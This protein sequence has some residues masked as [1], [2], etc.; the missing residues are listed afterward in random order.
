MKIYLRN[1]IVRTKKSIEQIDFSELVTFINGPVG[2]GKSTVARLIDYCFG[3]DLERTPA[4]QS[5]F[6]SAELNVTL[7]VYD[8]VIERAAEDTSI[9]RV[10]WSGPDNDIGSVNAPLSPQDTSLLDAEVYNFSD[11]IFHLCGVTP[12]MVK[13]RRRDPDSEMIRL[14]IRDILRYCYLEQDHL[15][16]SFFSIDDPFRGRKSQDAMRFFTGLHSERLSQIESQL[17]SAIDEQRGKREAVKQIREFMDMFDLGSKFNIIDYIDEIS[18]ELNEAKTKRQQLKEAR[19]VQIH[20]TDNLRIDLRKLSLISEELQMALIDS[21]EAI[22]EQN[23]LRAELITTKTK[24]ERVSKADGILDGVKFV[25]CP[26]CGIDISEREEDEDKCRLCGS[27]KC[28][29]DNKTPQELEA[30]RRDLNIRIDE[31]EDSISRRQLSSEKMTRELNKV[32]IRKKSLDEQLQ[33]ELSRYDSSII[34]SMLVVE[35]EIATLAERLTS[36][37]RLQ[38]MPQAIDELEVEAGTIQGQID[39]LRTSL[40]NETNRLKNANE[41]I[42]T[43]ADRFKLVMLSVGFPGVTEEDEVIVDPRNWK[44]MVVHNNQEWNFWDAGSGGKKTLFNVCYALAL[45]SVARDLNLPMPTILIIDSPTKNINEDENPDLVKS[46]YSEI[47]RTASEIS[48]NQLQF[49]LIDSVVVEPEVDLSS[50]SERRMSGEPDFPRL[51]SYYE[52]P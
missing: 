46:L 24:T 35:R 25:R 44:P 22:E 26:E 42:Q 3:G 37:E 8:C 23:A 49:L 14:S 36:F 19:A 20:P 2:T 17:F 41:V 33:D 15:D 50:Y 45:H 30:L 6:I 7:G 43:I 40:E 13:K 28:N 51:I 29:H 39:N 5:E 27:D 1:L 38:K 34:E 21:N 11:L 52:G 4:I 48:D 47:Y 18:Q 12:I 32:I 10:S 16:S 9:L 31:L